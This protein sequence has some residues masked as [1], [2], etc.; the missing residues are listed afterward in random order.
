[1]CHSPPHDVTVSMTWVKMSLPRPWHPS[2]SHGGA[3]FLFFRFV[4][5]SQCKLAPPILDISQLLYQ[6]LCYSLLSLLPRQPWT[7]QL[8]LSRLQVRKQAWNVGAIHLYSQH[9][10]DYIKIMSS[11]S[12]W[13][14]LLDPFSVVWY[15]ATHIHK[16]RKRGVKY[17][18]NYSWW[19]CQNCGIRN[20]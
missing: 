7:V 18:T 20:E 16:M 10:G 6:M 14:T 12:A 5:L 11:R 2:W 15:C 8:L 17:S 1:M 9:L 3:G 4:P 13:T 19:A